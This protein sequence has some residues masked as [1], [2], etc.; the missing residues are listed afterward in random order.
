MIKVELILMVFELLYQAEIFVIKCFSYNPI[1]T[2]SLELLKKKKIFFTKLKLLI[3]KLLVTVIVTVNVS[4]NS[5][6]V[7]AIKL[8]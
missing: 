8:Y 6:Q 7:N 3:F 1:Y 5:C 4:A 2:R